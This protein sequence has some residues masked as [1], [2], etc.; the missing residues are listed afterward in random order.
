MEHPGC[1]QSL[2]VINSAAV[3]MGVQ[4]ALSYPRTHS[5]KCMSRSGVAGSYDSSFLD[6]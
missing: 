5:F 2:A 4:M 3:D 1:F 6:F